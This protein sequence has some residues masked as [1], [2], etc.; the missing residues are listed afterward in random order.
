MRVPPGECIVM[1]YEHKYNTKRVKYGPIM[2]ILSYLDGATVHRV[3]WSWGIAPPF[4]VGAFSF[5]IGGPVHVCL[6][7]LEPCHL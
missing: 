4:P 5:S 7:L 1:Q 2:S 6:V 3:L